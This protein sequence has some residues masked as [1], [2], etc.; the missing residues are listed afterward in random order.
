[1]TM[2]TIMITMLKLA[3]LKDRP[4]ID[5]ELPAELKQR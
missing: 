5:K 4:K 2:R 1:M 3:D